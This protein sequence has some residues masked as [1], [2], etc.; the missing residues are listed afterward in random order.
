MEVLVS[1]DSDH[2]GAVSAAEYTAAYP[3]LMVLG[4]SMLAIE[5]DKRRILPET[6]D[7][8]LEESDALHFQLAYADIEGTGFT[9]D[10]NII[11]KLSRGHRQYLIVRDRQGTPLAEAM[12]TARKPQARVKAQSTGLS[13]TLF[14]YIAEGIWHI[15]IGLDHVLFL[16]TLMLPTVLVYRQR[17]WQSVAA[18]RPAV[19]DILKTVTAFS[20]AHSVTL[21]LA[22]LEV[23]SL[24]Q[25]WVESTIALSVLLVAINNLKPVS[26]ALSMASDLPMYCWIWDLHRRHLPYH[27]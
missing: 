3:R 26:S 2:D 12:L 14:H 22:V 27:W 9:V 10:S 4:E 16:L 11:T 25:H 13:M 23:V 7:I 8:E 24:P 1:M 6:V 21:S 5:I 20:L 15:F 19:I 17:R 18:L